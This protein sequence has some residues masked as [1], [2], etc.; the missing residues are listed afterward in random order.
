MRA[1]V[2]LLLGF[3]VAFQSIAVAHV[4]KPPCPMERGTQE[5]TLGGLAATADCC[6]DADMQAKTGKP[7]KAGQACN[8]SNAW[9]V[10]SLQAPMQVAASFRVVPAAVLIMPPFDPSG[11]WRPPTLS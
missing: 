4:F 3:T 2:S 11:V 7:C 5:V 6:N 8:L 9:A 1:L 10:T